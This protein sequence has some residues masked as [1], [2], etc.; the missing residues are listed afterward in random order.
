MKRALLALFFAL[1]LPGIAFAYDLNACSGSDFNA[2]GCAIIQGSFSANS[3]FFAIVFFGLFCLTMFAARAPAG[4][5]IGIG[6]ILL[7]SLSGFLGVFYTPLF[8]LMLVVIGVGIG[9]A[10]LHFVRY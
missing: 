8:N 6:V 7:F 9:L 3:V 2:I 10:I 1:F 5:A 4:A